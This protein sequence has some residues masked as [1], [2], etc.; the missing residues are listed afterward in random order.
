MD[1][2]NCIPNLR[3]RQESRAITEKVRQEFQSAALN[4]R[5][6]RHPDARIRLGRRDERKAG[7]VRGNVRISGR[8]HGSYAGL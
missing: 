7:D 2:A 4:Q 3:P 5:L 8:K 1:N 6:Y